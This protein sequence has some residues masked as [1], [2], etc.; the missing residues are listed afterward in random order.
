MPPRAPRWVRSLADWSTAFISSRNSATTRQLNRAEHSTYVH[1]HCLRTTLA[2]VS[3][4]RDTDVHPQ[5]APAYNRISVVKI[6]FVDQIQLNLIGRKC[7]Q[8]VQ[9]N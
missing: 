3:R 5:V 1:F 6:I 4:D 9:N 8:N 2:T 7:E